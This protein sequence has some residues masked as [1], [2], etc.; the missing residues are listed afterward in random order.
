[1]AK[2]SGYMSLRAEC[3]QS[4]ELYSLLM[5]QWLKIQR[6]VDGRDWVGGKVEAASNIAT[7]PVNSMTKTSV[8]FSLQTGG[9][10]RRRGELSS[11]RA[12][13]AVQ[14]WRDTGL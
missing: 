10:E 7:E 14:A 8:I 3:P 12:G 2:F 5:G 6:H 13:P 11:R 4:L 9:M 1:M